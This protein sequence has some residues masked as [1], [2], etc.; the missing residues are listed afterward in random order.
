MGPRDRSR[1]VTCA[2]VTGLALCLAFAAGTELGA[3]RGTI[4]ACVAPNGVLRV[5]GSSETCRS[6]ERLLTWNTAGPAG[7]AGAAGPA[8][9]R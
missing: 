5:I 4:S 2:A 1:G 3:Q 8:A 7:P 6:G 9:R